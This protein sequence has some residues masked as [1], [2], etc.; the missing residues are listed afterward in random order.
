MLTWINAG[1]GQPECR[2][3][4]CKRAVGGHPARFIYSAISGRKLKRPAAQTTQPV[5]QCPLSGAKR[6]SLPHRKMSAYDP[7]RTLPPHAPDPFQWA[8]LSRYDALS[9]SLEG[10]NET[11]RQNRRQIGKSA[12]P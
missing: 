12:R 5:Q 2:S 9:L 3:L 10:G 4:C 8:S 1:C 11:A 7:K 6:T